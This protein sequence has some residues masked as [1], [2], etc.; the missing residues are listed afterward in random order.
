MKLKIALILSCLLSAQTVAT[1]AVVEPEQKRQLCSASPFT[2]LPINVFSTSV[3]QYLTYQ[4]VCALRYASTSDSHYL[5]PIILRRNQFGSLLAS[6]FQAIT[7][8][9]YD[10]GYINY[11]RF[12]RLIKQ[13]LISQYTPAELTL[14]A[15][16]QMPLIPLMPLKEL[17]DKSWESR[18]D[19]LDKN[20]CNVPLENGVLDISTVFY[21][22][23]K[24]LDETD[25][26][27]KHSLDLTDKEYLKLTQLPPCVGQLRL[28][29][30]LK[31]SSPYQREKLHIFPEFIGNLTNLTELDM[32]DQKLCQIP[33]EIGQLI[34][35]KCLNLSR[36]KLKA[37]PESIGNLTN[38]LYLNLAENAIEQLPQ[39]IGA[40]VRLKHLRLSYNKISRLPI[41]MNQ[42]LD[43]RD[44]DLYQNNLTEF[45]LDLMA[46]KGLH[47]VML[48]YNPIGP[49]ELPDTILDLLNM[50]GE[51]PNCFHY[52]EEVSEAL[53]FPI[54]RFKF[55]IFLPM[56]LFDKI[57]AKF[58]GNPNV[59]F[60]S[61]YADSFEFLVWRFEKDVLFPNMT[62]E[63]LQQFRAVGKSIE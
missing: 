3:C 18:V 32:Q 6:N 54:G 51:E 29:S 35:L 11:G 39:S 58:K 26:S 43:L 15:N 45:P 2:L 62:D 27:K 42:L 50:Q 63:S 5:A 10:Y 25:K 47:E 28:L 41:Q 31:L 44:L 7:F 24:E 33:P 12:L 30:S 19:V 34:K 61:V 4:D 55:C 60:R 38:L 21:F 16:L 9:S 37:L 20:L 1:E 52:E 36:N 8:S 40:L 53:T 57:F 14:A 22:T 46:L 56:N 59:I 49:I 17:I 48:S 23:Q 13:L